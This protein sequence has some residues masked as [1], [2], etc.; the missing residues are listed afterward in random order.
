MRSGFSG[1]S[2]G[3]LELCGALVPLVGLRCQGSPFTVFFLAPCDMS[4]GVQGDGCS[5]SLV[6][7]RAD[8]GVESVPARVQ[9]DGQC[10]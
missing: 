8:L 3:L 9:F 4:V 10:L 5:T 1:T 6:H 2:L 7:F